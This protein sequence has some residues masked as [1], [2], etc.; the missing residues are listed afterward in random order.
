MIDFK[1]YFKFPLIVGPYCGIYVW[2]SNHTTTFNYLNSQA[3]LNDDLSELTDIVDAIN[4][5]AP[6][7]FNAEICDNMIISIDG[8]RKLIIRGWGKLIGIG[9]YHLSNDDAE[10]VQ[11]QMLEYC[12]KMLRRDL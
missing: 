12:V 6:G 5:N 1:D 2:D 7:K 11:Q 3:L 9:G 4:G 8:E 10:K